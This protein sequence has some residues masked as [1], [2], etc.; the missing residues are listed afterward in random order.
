MWTWTSPWISKQS[1]LDGVMTLCGYL[2]V[3]CALFAAGA[4]VADRSAERERAAWPQATA[5]V[6]RCDVE[7]VYSRMRNAGG[8]QWHIQCNGRITIDE[9]PVGVSFRSHGVSRAGEVE[10]MRR[11]VQRHH[12]GTS[13]PVRYDPDR[14]RSAVAEPSSMPY[15]GSRVADDETLALIFAA[16]GA[17]LLLGGRVVRRRGAQ[18]AA[19]VASSSA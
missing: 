19:V 1:T 17:L 2:G 7:R 6:Q 13:I 10:E 4:T 18:D 14:P 12:A 11:W 8:P 16:G 15:S 5:V 9:K 3:L